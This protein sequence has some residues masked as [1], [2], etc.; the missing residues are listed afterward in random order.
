MDFD[1]DPDYLDLDDILAN[2][3][4]V[5]CIFLMNIPGLEFLSPGDSQDAVEGADLMLPFWMA[6]T[7]YTYSM[8]DIELPKVYNT[9]FRENLVAA[10]NRV[11]LHLNGPNYYRFGK[12]LIGLKREKGNN[13]EMYTA[14]GQRNK[15]RREEGETLD[16]R[17]P[18]EE[19]L[20]QSFHTRRH[21]ILEYSTNASYGDKHPSLLAFES[22][23]DNMEKRLFNLGRLQVDSM[24]KWDSRKIEM[25]SNNQIAIRLAKRRKLET[26][27]Q[28]TLTDNHQAR[29]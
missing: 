18:I 3:Q 19:S 23:L 29:Q 14:E 22:R 4:T 2:T 8:I 5:K 27:V 15:Y 13:L 28:D 20:I 16:D 17:R 12:L 26:S 10:A 1:E 11:D 25:I 24:K 7:L 6:R 21:S 9:T